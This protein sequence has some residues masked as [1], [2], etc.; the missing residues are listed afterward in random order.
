[1]PVGDGWRGDVGDGRT[2]GSYSRAGRSRGRYEGAH[3][4]RAE[5][6]CGVAGRLVAHRGSEGD[7]LADSK[8]SGY[9]S[10]GQI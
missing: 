3:G 6:P 7:G 1:L 2:G 4:G 10:D 5:G 9:R 8:Q